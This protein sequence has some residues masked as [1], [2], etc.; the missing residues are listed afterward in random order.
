ML[1][2]P[3]ILL[4]L[5]PG[6]FGR[7]K[8]DYSKDGSYGPS[9]WSAFS[10]DCSAS[11]ARQSPI[12]LDVVHSIMDGSM[13]ELNFYNYDTVLPGLKLKNSGHSVQVDV[14][15]ASNLTIGQG[16]LPATYR[17]AQFHFHW[18]DRDIVGSEHTVNG[19]SYP[20]ELHLVHVHRGYDEEDMLKGDALAVVGVFFHVVEDD[21]PSANIQP[22]LDVLDKVPAKGSIEPLPTL[23][24]RDFLP[25]EQDTFWRYLGSLT[26]PPC[27]ESVVW[28]V[29]TNSLPI[30][31]SQLEV[32]RRVELQNAKS[33]NFRPEQNLKNR[34][35]YLRLPPAQILQQSTASTSTISIIMVGSAIF[36]VLIR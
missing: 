29:F 36:A 1:L 30:K 23:D 19:L 27:T 31:R 8:W 5:C 16:G 33:G 18:A 13:K 28:T 20:L 25:K 9:K 35:I 26:T 21:Q 2:I 32:F 24:L 15:A 11:S 7:G 17:L 4:I 14:D 10:K 6:G 12:D 34:K 22:F 3:F